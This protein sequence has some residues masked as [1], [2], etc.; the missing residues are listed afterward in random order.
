MEQV[1]RAE[2]QWGDSKFGAA[3]SVVAVIIFGLALTGLCA[4]FLG[5]LYDGYKAGSW[6]PIFQNQFVAI[7]GIPFCILAAVC[8][9]LFFR[10]FHGPIAFEVGTLKFSGATGPVVLWIFCFFVL[11]IAMKM[12]WS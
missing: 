7:V 9:V 11:V 4:L 5:V 8:V 10:G 12:L 3:I 2:G 6:L 1:S